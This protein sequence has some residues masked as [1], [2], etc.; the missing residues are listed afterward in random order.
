MHLANDWELKS[1]FVGQEK[2]ETDRQT[3]RE[4]PMD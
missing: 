4:I 3:D 1:C 2:T